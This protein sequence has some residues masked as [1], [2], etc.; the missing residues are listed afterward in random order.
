MYKIVFY[1]DERGR[2]EVADYL[3]ELKQKRSA[4][5]D[6]NIK[7]HK[8]TGCIMALKKE[9]TWVG[10]PVVKHIG[11]GIWELRPEDSRIFFFFWHKDSF[12]LLSHYLKKSKKTPRRELEKA[13][14]YRKSWIERKGP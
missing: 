13:K 7:W 14:R 8:I 5:K 1:E 12:V 2:S 9:G 10:A 6:A 3:M 4:V 11:D